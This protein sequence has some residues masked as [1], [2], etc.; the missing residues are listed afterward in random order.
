MP[1]ANAPPGAGGL[2]WSMDS[3]EWP[4]GPKPAMRVIPGVILIT[5]MRPF[6]TVNMAPEG[7]R[8]TWPFHPGS[9]CISHSG[10]CCFY[11]YKKSAVLST[12]Q[13]NSPFLCVM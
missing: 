9:T 6:V 13:G 2:S 7:P 12:E 3:Q 4:A 11:I 5:S 8:Q 10:D 1:L